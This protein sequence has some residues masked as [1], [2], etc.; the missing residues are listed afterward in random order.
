M[1][2][3][4]GITDML[5]FSGI[6]CPASSVPSAA[7]LDVQVGRIGLRFFHHGSRLASVSGIGTNDDMVCDEVPE[8]VVSVEGQVIGAHHVEAYGMVE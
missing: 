2:L 4:A 6:G 7:D 8:L 3:A 5:V 1:F